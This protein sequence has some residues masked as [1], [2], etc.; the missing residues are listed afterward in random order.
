[1]LEVDED[2]AEQQKEE[3]AELEQSQDSELIRQRRGVVG[4]RNEEE[5]AQ[6]LDDRI[7]RTD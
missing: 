2:Q 7:S 4:G 1:M 3:E 5:S 6:E